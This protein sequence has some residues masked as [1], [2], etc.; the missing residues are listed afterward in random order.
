MMCAKCEK[1]FQQP[2]KLNDEQK[3][4][5]DICG[6]SLEKLDGFYDRHPNLKDDNRTEGI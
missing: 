6:T 1:S 5:C 4:I 2:F 3:P